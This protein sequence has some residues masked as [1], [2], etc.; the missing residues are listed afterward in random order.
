MRE[1]LLRWRDPG[2]LSKIITKQGIRDGCKKAILARG[3]VNKL[4][5][6]LLTKTMF[7]PLS[8]RLL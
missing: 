7:N 4:I 3:Q 1:F 5:S 8:V 6:G 2:Y